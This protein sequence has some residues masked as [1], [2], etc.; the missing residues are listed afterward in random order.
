MLSIQTDALQTKVLWNKSALVKQQQ[1]LLIHL[2]IKV[3][4]F[5]ALAFKSMALFVEG[6]CM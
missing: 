3:I 2:K 5:L 4:F 1:N 6:I